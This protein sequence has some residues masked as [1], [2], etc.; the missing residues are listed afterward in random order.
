MSHATAMWQMPAAGKS[1]LLHTNLC[2][3]LLVRR[4]GVRMTPGQIQFSDSGSQQAVQ[5][6]ST[7]QES[8]MMASS[9]GATKILL[10][11]TR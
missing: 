5:Y 7:I 11:P 4:E 2:C 3:I 1:G 6:G 10:K 8:Q 9:H